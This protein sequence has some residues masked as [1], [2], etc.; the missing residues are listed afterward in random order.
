MKRQPVAY[1]HRLAEFIGCPISREEEANGVV[2]DILRLCSFDYLSTLE[3]NKSGHMATGEK[4]DAFFRK[5][6]IG[7]WLNYLTIE[8]IEK[9]DRITEEKF[10]DAGLRF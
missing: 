9:L 3:V 8:M 2:N 4:H 1:L 7:D 10:S 5:G 6:N